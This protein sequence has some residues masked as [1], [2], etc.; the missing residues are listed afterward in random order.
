MC[1][2][3]DYFSPALAQLRATG[4]LYQLRH[5][6]RAI[7]LLVMIASGAVAVTVTA[8]N[9]SFVSRWV[10]SEQYGGYKL[11]LLI[12]AGMVCRHLAFTWWNAAFILG[13]ERRVACIAFAD[14]VV[15]IIASIA[16]SAAIGVVGV[17]LGSLT[18]VLL[19]FGPVGL[20]TV[21]AAIGVTPL[22]ILKWVTSWAIRFAFVF[23]PIAVVSSTSM[24]SS[25][26]VASG[27]VIA[28]LTTYS[29]A[30]Y[31][32]TSYPPLREYRDRSASRSA[33]TTWLVGKGNSS[34]R[35]GIVKSK[36][37]H[38]VF[39]RDVN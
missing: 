15:T 6:I 2:H 23:G 19:V 26:L 14:G 24:S 18:G 37:Y 12:V 33:R 28:G 3:R 31:L 21:S 8:V 25:V 20:L 1:Y 9:E 34:I 39:G 22:V 4:D 27:L 29:V 35:I 36:R 17:P 32:L 5:A 16:W 13:F 7:S 10:G 30:M 11:S 38:G